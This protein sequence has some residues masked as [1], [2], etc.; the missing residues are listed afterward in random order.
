MKAKERFV[1]LGDLSYLSSL[2][3]AEAFKNFLEAEAETKENEGDMRT[4]GVLWD[5]SEMVEQLSKSVKDL[6]ETLRFVVEE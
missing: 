4:A 6:R 5:A 2:E 3:V 1:G